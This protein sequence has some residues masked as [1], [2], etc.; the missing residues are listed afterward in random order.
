MNRLNTIYYK[1]KSE[2]KKYSIN[3]ETTEL[4]IGDIKK[5]IIKRRNLEKPES[6]LIFYDE[7][8]NRINGDD[9]FK[10]EPLRLLIIKRL[11][12]DKTTKTYTDMMDDQRDIITGKVS[13]DLPAKPI[14]SDTID[15][16]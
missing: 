9:N 2:K 5:I 16:S 13:N 14:V 10:I 1:F 8:M 7:N 11:P 6:V 4:S 15:S 3:F 12:S